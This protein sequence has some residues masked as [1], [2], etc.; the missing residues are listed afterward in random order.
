MDGMGGFGP[1][2]VT[3]VRVSSA[4]TSNAI[5]IRAYDATVTARLL[6]KSY[7]YIGRLSQRN[8]QDMGG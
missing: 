7:T 1:S 8:G 4:E 5:R 3:C 6:D 2:Y